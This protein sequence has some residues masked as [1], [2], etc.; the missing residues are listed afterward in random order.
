[1]IRE[2]VSNKIA[3]HQGEYYQEHFN[4]IRKNETYRFVT[5]KILIHENQ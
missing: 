3:G 5:A 1:M 4:E 2:E